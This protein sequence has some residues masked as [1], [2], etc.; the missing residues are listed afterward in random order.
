MGR[1]E[2]PVDRTVP[3]RA[4]L[5][6][7]LRARKTAVGLT[8]EQ[9]ADHVLGAPSKATFERAASGTSVP[10]WTTVE[11]FVTVTITK[12]EEFIGSIDSAL[13]CALELWIRA[14]RATRAPYY[15]HKAPDPDLIQSVADFSRALRDQHV[16]AGYPSPGEMERMSDPGELPSTTTRRIIQ[17]RTLP[18]SPHQ[19]IAFLKACH[20][21]LYDLEPWISAGRRAFEHDKPHN[22]EAYAWYKAH[23][24]WRHQI[25]MDTPLR[26]LAA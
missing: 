24:R 2:N 10:S 26:S 8:H 21:N 19:A 15:V 25:S 4:E 3:A 1:P 11:A 14:R 5:A 18:A 9:M 13:T 20:V 17:G 12:E 23:A 6:D 16:W 7:F 22:V